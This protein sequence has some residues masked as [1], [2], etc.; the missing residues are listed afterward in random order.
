MVIGSK[1]RVQAR[2]GLQL[3]AYALK[4]AT[5]CGYEIVLALYGF[6]F[7]S[8]HLDMP[9]LGQGFNGF[10]MLISVTLC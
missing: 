9:G 8:P 6:G 5:G 4:S 7:S 2:A 10:M 3:V 1:F